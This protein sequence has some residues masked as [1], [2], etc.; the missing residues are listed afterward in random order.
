MGSPDKDPNKRKSKVSKE[1]KRNIYY[2]SKAL[3]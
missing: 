3:D 1:D 2:L